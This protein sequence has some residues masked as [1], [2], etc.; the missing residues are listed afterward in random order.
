VIVIQLQHCFLCGHNIFS[1]G[2]IY[3]SAIICGPSAFA[4]HCANTCDASVV[5]AYLCQSSQHC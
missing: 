4:V 3:P 1:T 5:T 2:S